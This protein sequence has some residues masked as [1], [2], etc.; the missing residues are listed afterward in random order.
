[1]DKDSHPQARG[2][3][4]DSL[5]HMVEGGNWILE[6]VPDLPA[7]AVAHVYPFPPSTLNKNIYTPIRWKSLKRKINQLMGFFTYFLNFVSS[8]NLVV[9]NIL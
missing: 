5:N 1:M 7:Q 8:L 9:N 4:F 2:T 3:E 6:V